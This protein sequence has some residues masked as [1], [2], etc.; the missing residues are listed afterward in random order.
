[1]FF[2]IFFVRIL[3]FP[4]IYAGAETGTDRRRGWP[5]VRDP[6]GSRAVGIPRHF[7]HRHGHGRHQQSEPTVFVPQIRRRQAQVGG[8]CCLCQQTRQGFVLLIVLYNY[9]SVPVS[10][11]PPRPHLLMI[12]GRIAGV[13]VT[14][15]VGRIESKPKTWYKKFDL[16]VAG[17]DNQVSYPRSTS[18][19]E[20]RCEAG[21]D[22]CSRMAQWMIC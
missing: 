7:G 18:A 15:Y 22:S 3:T 21:G 20:R 14:P 12:G 11:V 19:E 5:W 17:L 13:T 9:G 16:V 10:V 8:R 4:T 6:Q 2:A 1:M